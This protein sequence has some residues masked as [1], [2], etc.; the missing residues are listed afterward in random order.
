MLISVIIPVYNVESFLRECLDSVRAQ[1]CT[2]WEAICIDDGSTDRSGAILDEYAAMD[3]RFRVIHKPNEGVSVARNLGL[4]M[5]GGE[6]VCFVDGDDTVTDR[7]LADYRDAI[8]R[9]KYDVVR[10]RSLHDDCRGEYRDGALYSWWWN[11]CVRDG[12]PWMYCV[13][14]NVAVVEAFPVG[15]A[16]GEDEIYCLRLM[17]HVKSACQLESR[18]YVHRVVGGSAMFRRLSSEERL[19][20]LESLLKSVENSPLVVPRVLTRMLSDA[21][22][23]W[24]CRPADVTRR[25]D[26]REMTLKVSTPERFS[27]SGMKRIDR[28]P[29]VL[30]CWCGWMWPY[31]I[32]AHTVSAAV[33]MKRV[34]G[35]RS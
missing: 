21:V 6:Y 8:K 16:M 23:A 10:M 25:R 15:V 28:V 24:V 33:W 20:Y 22:A 13:R 27:W 19:R 26:I 7:W 35:R 12:Y 17:S 34:F 29:F 32:V 31:A 14:R 9:F 4:S 1:L 3:G 2:D 30:F 11:E 5:A 18:G